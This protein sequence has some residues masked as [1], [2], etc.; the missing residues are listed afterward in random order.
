MSYLNY[1][2]VLEQNRYLSE[3]HLKFR[4]ERQRKYPEDINV[5]V[6]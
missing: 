5:Y 3:F 6:T 2:Y 1:F 4:H